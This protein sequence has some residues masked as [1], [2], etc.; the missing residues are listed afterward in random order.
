MSRHDNTRQEEGCRIAV[1]LG[2]RSN[3]FWT[4]MVKGYES[5]APSTGVDVACFFAD[6]EK[7]REAQL[8]KLL[9]ILTLRFDA[10]IV[11]PISKSNLVTGILRAAEDGIPI[12]DVGAKTDPTLVKDA[13]PMYRP[14]RTVDFFAQRLMAGSY[15]CRRLLALGGGK[16]AIIEG[17]PDSAQSLGRSA[18]AAEAFG[19]TPAIQLV[20]RENA[21]FDRS[22]A[23]T[24]SRAIVE[25]MPD[26]K[27]F[28]CAND[29][30]A[31]GVS[32]TIKAWPGCS[33]IVVVGVDL[34]PDTRDAIRRGLITASVAF[35]PEAVAKVVLGAVKRVLSGND[36]DEGFP[37][38]SSLV[39]ADTVDTYPG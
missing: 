19:N 27:A 35:S 16:V 37:V 36:L 30:M 6:P 23:A 4:E 20:C 28:F 5:F 2:D 3:P 13:G 17:R 32:D 29:V 34:T 21:D 10:V 12:L 33:G 22:K 39:D 15:I 24:V 9:D 18:G 8:A 38:V 25:R 26:I 14:V 11:N 7:D 1:L 31:L